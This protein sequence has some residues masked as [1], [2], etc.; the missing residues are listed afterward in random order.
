M[1]RLPYFINLSKFDRFENPLKITSLSELGLI[2]S[3]FILF[4][5]PKEI[6]LWELAVSQLGEHHRDK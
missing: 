2:Y 4:I 1:I 3:R 6:F 5:Q